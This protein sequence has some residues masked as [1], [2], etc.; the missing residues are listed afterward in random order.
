MNRLSLIISLISVLTAVGELPPPRVVDSHGDLLPAGALLR[1]GK[2]RFGQGLEGL[3]LSPDGK[4]IRSLRWGVY[5]QDFEYETGRLIRTRKLP[6]EPANESNLSRDGSTVLMVRRPGGWSGPCQVEV[7]DLERGTRRTT[8]RLPGGDWSFFQLSGDGQFVVRAAD[9]YGPRSAKSVRVTVWDARTGTE[10]GQADMD[11]PSAGSGWAGAPVF[12]PD[13]RYLMYSCGSSGTGFYYCLDRTTMKV[14]W[15][16]TYTG[17][18][19]PEYLP[20]GRVLIPVPGSARVVSWANGEESPVRLPPEFRI[21]TH[22]GFTG[23]GKTFLYVTGDGE[24]RELRA[25]DWQDGRPV[26]GLRPLPLGPNAWA[27]GLLTRDAAD[28]W[29]IDG[30]WRRYDLRTGRPVWP[31]SAEAGH[32]EAVSSLVLSADGRTLASAS[33]DMSVRLWD[34]TTGRALR[35]WLAAPT[36]GY[37]E[38]EPGNLQSSTNTGPPAVDLSADG[39]RL[40]L[41]DPGDGKGPPALR[42]IDTRTGQTVSTHQMP[43]VKTKAGWPAGFGRIQF[44]AD[45]ACLWTSYGEW[46]ADQWSEPYHTLSRW[47]LAADRWRDLG[48]TR[49]GPPARSAVAGSR[50]LA[51]GVAYDADTGRRAFELTGYAYGTLVSSPDGRLVAGLGRTAAGPEVR[52]PLEPYR[53]VRV[54]DARTGHPIARLPWNPPGRLDRPDVGPGAVPA[55]PGPTAF[56]WPRRFALH[57][58]GRW[59]VT[60]DPEG[61]RL[62]DLVSCRVVHTFP[63]PDRPPVERYHGSP[64]TALAFTP[65]GSRLATGMPDGTILLWPVP[66]PTP[67][68][69]KAGELPTLWA[70]LMG[71]DPA[72]GWRAAWRLMDDPAAAVRLIRTN[73][74]PAERAAAAEVAKLLAD[75]DSSEFRRREAATRRLETVI[76]QV[77]SAVEEAEKAAGASPELRERLHQVLA[78]ATGDDK[79]LP[80]RAAAQSRAV[81]VLEHIHTPDARAALRDLASGAPGAWLTRDAK[82]ALARLE[83]GK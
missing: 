3:F 69:P 50:W 23:G 8:I 6:A 43:Q 2:V 1:L 55:N 80:D 22:V 11:T 62:W 72:K 61:V 44:A 13:N 70:D 29:V 25:W 12:S 37:W 68:P 26:A 16:K 47:D 7:W 67:N 51:A 38:W 21:S 9:H 77:R 64:A 53:E 24:H 59:F 5:L 74:Q 49:P 19:F 14:V 57:P 78:M 48:C 58:S 45:G 42:V 73:L 75:A 18:G 65:D 79:A 71:S 4:T 60:A 39:R 76:D 10:V 82:A 41:V 54:W 63:V 35:R 20:D 15:E 33:E 32:T 40:A 83:L 28:V 56:A 66:I 46:D 31:N 30:G 81:A 17:A 27:S 36:G 52:F 34:V